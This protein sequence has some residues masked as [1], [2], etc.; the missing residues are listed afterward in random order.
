MIEFII[1]AVVLG[2]LAA[3]AYYFVKGG[4]LF[5]TVNDQITDAVT[6]A[7]PAE[8]KTRKPRKPRAPKADVAAKKPRKPRPPLKK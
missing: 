2:C 3:A 8:K 1:T 7:A 4:K 5:T 6:Q